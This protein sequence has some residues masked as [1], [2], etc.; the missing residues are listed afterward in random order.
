MA[1]LSQ[2][3]QNQRFR[4]CYW[5]ENDTPYPL[6]FVEPLP[7]PILVQIPMVINSISSSISKTPARRFP[8]KIIDA[9][10]N[11]GSLGRYD[12]DR[13][14]DERL[15][16]DKNT[17]GWSGRQTEAKLGDRLGSVLSLASKLAEEAQRFTTLSR[18]F[19]S[20]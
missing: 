18:L 4:R 15:L 11:G 10:K 12:N 6:T 1:N 7:W 8:A 5:F 9:Y 13:A 2:G 20:R 17:R 19:A 14:I 3:R 16:T